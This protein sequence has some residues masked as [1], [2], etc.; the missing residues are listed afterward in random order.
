VGGKLNA[1]V[2]CLDRHVATA[3]RNKVALL[4]EGEPGD[5]R[6]LTYWELYREVNQ[7]A[8]ALRGLG[9]RRGDRVAILADN[10]CAWVVAY[11]GAL[12]QGAVAAPLN[13]RHAADDLDR[14]LDDLDPAV[15]V[16]DPPYLP[17]LSERY[18]SRV[19][20]SSDV[21]VVGRLAPALDGSA[22]RP[23]EIGVLCYT[24]GTT[25]RPKGAIITPRTAWSSSPSTCGSP[26]SRT[27]P[28]RAPVCRDAHRRRL[29][30]LPEKRRPRQRNRPHGSAPP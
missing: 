13:T 2:N 10:G 5:R 8:N 12:A 17:R 28:A 19:L 11:L 7:F 25:G 21:D 16:G 6:A 26:P 4:W 3:R 18:R 1:S 22:A 15:I 24:S 27:A 23:E 30:R 14:V 20:V 29:P 9:V